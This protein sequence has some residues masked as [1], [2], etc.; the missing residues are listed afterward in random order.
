LKVLHPN[1]RFLTL[2]QSPASPAGTAVIELSVPAQ[3][4]G[5]ELLQTLRSKLPG[6]HSASIDPG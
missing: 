4:D 1:A 5:L 2:E 6:V 3:G